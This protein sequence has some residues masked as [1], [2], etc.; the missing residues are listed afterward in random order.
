MLQ[1]TARGDTL[2]PIEVVGNGLIDQM[3]K[4]AKSNKVQVEVVY[5]LSLIHI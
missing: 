5:E 4:L 1:V 3:K 2:F